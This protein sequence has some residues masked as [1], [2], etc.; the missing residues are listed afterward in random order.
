MLQTTARAIDTQRPKAPGPRPLEAFDIERVRIAAERIVAEQI[1]AHPLFR[2]L[3]AR[4]VPSDPAITRRRLLA[5]SLRLTDT[6]APDAYQQAREAQRVLGLSGD[7]ELY[8]SGGREN[9]AIHL[10]EAPI[11]MEVQGRLLPL[12]DAGSSLALFG[13]ELG[14][15]LA[16]G[17]WAQLGAVHVVALSASKLASVPP[18]LESAL[19]GLSVLR[20]LTADRVGLLA[21]Q[22]LHAAL[23]LEMVATTGLSAECLTWDTAAYLVQCQELMRAVTKE[24]GA[25]YAGSHP[26]H[27][28]R[29]YALWLFSESQ[30]YHALTGKGPGSRLLADVDEHLWQLLGS[31]KL[32]AG[33]SYHMLDEP[34]R[35]LQ[36]CALAACVIVA[37]ADG[38]VSDEEIA[39]IENTF[40]PLVGDWREYL[41]LDF[42]HLRFREVAPVI[43]AGGTD[44]SHSLF[45]LLVHVMA[46]DGTMARE[47]AAAILFVGSALGCE[48][49]YARR[50][51]STLR[52]LKLTLALERARATP[53]PL[54]A[55]NDEVADAFQAFLAGV[56]RRGETVT[57]LR[58]LLRLLG[59]TSPTGELLTQIRGLL[60][61]R[62]IVADS[63]LEQVGLDERIHLEAP[64]ARQDPPS[65]P[66]APELAPSRQNLIRALTRLREQLVS[67][68]GRSPSVRVRSAVAG[69]IFDLHELEKVSAG[70]AERAL[71]QLGA[72]EPALLVDP[73]EAGSHAAA[74][75]AGSQLLALDR[76]HRS[77]L[78]ETGANDL[79]LGYP[80]V[81][82]NV[83]PQKGAPYFVRAPLVLYPVTLERHGQGAPGYR[84]CPREDEPVIINQ[85][86]LRLIFNKAGLSYSD[87]ISD[88]LDLLISSPDNNTDTLLAKL[89]GYGL[90]IP[91]AASALGPL[92]EL[93]AEAMAVAPTLGMQECALLGL[94]PQSSSDLLQDYDGLLKALADPQQDI[95]SILGAADVLLPE[96]LRRP[97]LA[98]AEASPQ[99]AAPVAAADPV[100]RR[101]IADC[102]R[103]TATV[104]DGPPGTGKSQVIVN[105]V[106]DAL[107]RGERVAVVCEKRAALDVVFQRLNALGFRHGVGIVHDVH[108]DRKVLYRQV[109]ER[110]EDFVPQST[111]EQE[112]AAQ[113]GEHEQVRLQLEQRAAAL[114]AAV[115]SGLSIGQLYSLV[116]GIPLPHLDADPALASI[117]KSDLERLLETATTLHPLQDT[118]V[119]GSVFRD[120]AGHQRRSLASWGTP[121]LKQLGVNIQ[122]ALDAARAHAQQVAHCPAPIDAVVAA[123]PALQRARRSRADRSD[124]GSAPLFASLLEVAQSAPAQLQRVKEASEM[125]EWASQAIARFDTR[126]DFPESPQLQH[127]VLVLKQWA[128][129]WLRCFVWAWWRAR[130]EVRKALISSWP[131]RSAEPFGPTFAAEVHDRFV[132]AKAWRI[133]LAYIAALG[134]TEHSPSTCSALASLL[135]RLSLL[136]PHAVEMS[137]DRAALT[138]AEA[139]PVGADANRAFTAWDSTVDQRITV[140]EAREALRSSA[141]P[142]HA[143]FRWVGE[144]PAPL[145]LERLAAAVESN[146]ERLVDAH[147]QLDGAQ[148]VFAGAERLLDAV[149]ALTRDAGADR[150]RALIA[151]SWGQAILRNEEAS[152]PCLQNLGTASDDRKE[153]RQ[154]KQLGNLE[155]ALSELEVER[156]L[157]RMD[158]AELLHVP[159]AAKGK[160]RTPQQKIREELLKEANKK[161]S[162]LPLR[163]FVR[164][165]AAEGLLGLLPVWLLSPETMAILF[166]RGPLFDLVVFDEASQCT[167]EAGLPVLARARRVVVAG[168]EKQMPP[169]SFFASNSSSDEDEAQPTD[170]EQHRELQDMLTA[171]SLLNLARSRVPHTGLAW[172]YRCRDEALIAFSNHALYHGDLLTIPAT[173]TPAASSVIR[174]VP[175]E[176]GVYDTGANLP[177]AEAVVD[178]LYELLTREPAPSIGIVTFNIRQRRTILDTIDARCESSADFARLWREAS[179]GEAVDQRPFVKNLENVQGDERDVI[180]FS[181]GHAPQERRRGGVGTGEFYVPARFGPLGQRGGERRLNV[182]ISRAKAECCV[183]ASFVP[184]QLSVAQS[185]HAGPG[186]FKQFLEFAHHKSAGRHR[187]A[188]QVLDLVRETRLS[189]LHR[190]GPPPLECFIPL[191][192]QLHDALEREGV[193]LQLDVGASNFRVPLAVLDPQDPTRFVLAILPEEGAAAERDLSAFDRH[194]H[195]PGVL[196]DR[197]WLTYRVSSASWQ[198]RR[199]EVLQ[200]ILALVPGAKGATANAVWRSHRAAST[201]PPPPPKPARSA[202]RLAPVHLPPASAQDEETP[203]GEAAAPSI[204]EWAQQI[205]NPRFRKALLHLQA[206]GRLNETEL[207]NLVGGPRQARMFARQLDGWLELLPFHVEVQ[208]VGENKVYRNVGVR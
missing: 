127:A 114:S 97:S 39:I 71:Q 44:L 147:R 107:R 100:Q 180:V 103:N 152:D 102:R 70:R 35:E 129:T 91:T 178:L 142:V 117:T 133:I 162:V 115:G 49:Q 18:E 195:R 169:S 174:W 26:E 68:D 84:V 185:R 138:A 171:E 123:L 134:L 159:P 207:V 167:V 15:Y 38:H 131:E 113:R 140:L 1:T 4:Y 130:T 33:S 172:H 56:L 58:R 205:E 51:E 61:S 16:H 148:A 182:A 66:P 144:L 19:Q 90:V 75:K 104:V 193:P 25:I 7:I 10:V 87:E 176:N 109:A 86:L 85:S 118:W 69:R 12:L 31:S 88:E 200:E 204:P 198:K 208:Q 20:E 106:A 98:P 157:S 194:V 8:Q 40:A 77:R 22:D 202:P 168:D 50:L 73:K 72:F 93:D 67:G 163:T 189:A 64:Q 99:P 166:P 42:A 116:A 41:D 24:G 186:L 160:R 57:T 170:D 27:S 52:S 36:E 143:A 28:L 122:A 146:G 95:G 181:L 120:P 110:L 154:V 54:P 121:Q 5:Q 161:K 187:P 89:A 177:E 37:H 199:D 55:R 62:G 179:A 83:I 145:V 165:Y 47:E 46:A 14:H 136:M 150:W 128:G 11:V 9:A 59:S 79:Y 30:E 111:D 21:S 149:V 184:S 32:S 197:G 63:E 164:R 92:R 13:H 155:R 108:E 141:S 17:P 173:A 183:V 96:A 188:E 135:R 105:L 6:M 48:S 94:F 153:G 2:A 65:Q 201:A 112:A 132:A 3:A 192:V 158:R 82:G 126:V 53:L 125:Y 203:E 29:A 191:I 43:A 80:L 124:T 139:W 60:A 175:V 101:V 119:S 76:E 23:R 196:R 137:A 34:P 78:E 74:R 81:A 206:H 45:S 156:I 190:E 151:A